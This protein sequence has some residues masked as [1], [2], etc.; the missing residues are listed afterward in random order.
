MFSKQLHF[1]DFLYAWEVGFA[2]F[3]L[4]FPTF[5]LHYEDIVTATGL[6]P[7]LVLRQ[8]KVLTIRKFFL[9]R[10]KT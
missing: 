10:E 3:P 5:I 1:T 7:V 6:T 9:R 4:F 8:R 2:H